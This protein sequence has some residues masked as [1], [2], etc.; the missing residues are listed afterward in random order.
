MKLFVILLT[1]CLATLAHAQERIDLTTPIVKPIASSWVYDGISTSYAKGQ[2]EAHFYDTGTGEWLTCKEP[3]FDQARA[4]ITLLNK[5][6]LGGGR[7]TLGSRMIDRYS[8]PG[9]CLGQGTPAGNAR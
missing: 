2:F 8:G 6:N 5:A 1:L 7:N 3:D 9:K 4:L